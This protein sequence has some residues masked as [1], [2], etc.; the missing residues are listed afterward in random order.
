MI[1]IR[2]FYR[3]IENTINCWDNFENLTWR[4]FYDFGIFNNNVKVYKWH[5]I[6]LPL[7]ITTFQL[8][9]DSCIQTGYY[10]NASNPMAH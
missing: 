8:Y 5:S 4:F 3:Y 10:N 9:D 2:N 1:S 6:N 7:K